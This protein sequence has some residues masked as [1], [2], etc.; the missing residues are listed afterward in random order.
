MR[1]SCWTKLRRIGSAAVVR[2][3]ASVGRASTARTAAAYA[4]HAA[5]PPRGS[6]SAQSRS[7]LVRLAASQ[8]VVLGPGDAQVDG[9]APV[10]GLEGGRGGAAQAVDGQS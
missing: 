10:A 7:G 4:L 6:S 2:F 8:G 9:G 3:G 5:A 1:L